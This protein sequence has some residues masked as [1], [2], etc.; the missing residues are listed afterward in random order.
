MRRRYW[1]L[2]ASLLALAIVG[3]ATSHALWAADLALPSPS[4]SAP[5]LAPLP[6][7]DHG[8]AFLRFFTD[9]E[10]YFSWGFSKQYWANSDIH[11]SQP[12]L[13]NGFTV[14]NVQGVD[15]QITA[16]QVF[17]DPFGGEYNIRIGR[18]LSDSRAF[19][20]ELSFDHTKYTTVVGQTANVSGVIGGVPFNGPL[21]LSQQTFSEVLHN[22]A[23]HLMLN[24]VYRLPL[25]G[26][27]DETM[28]LAALGKVG[29]G[30]MLPHTTDTI[31]GNTNFVG[32]KTF[33]NA[34]GLT[35]GWW[36][37]NGW[38]LGAEAA[39]R[40]VIYKPVY[41]EVSDKVAFARLLDL[42]AP[43]GTIQQ[44]LWM[45]EFVVSLGVTYDG[46]STATRR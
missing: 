2:G 6:P 17:G 36:Q 19:G 20:V 21:V 24:A 26:Q 10:W 4:P 35:N 30:V 34:I 16:S 39:L 43:L 7:P 11:V 12:A 13:G 32:T 46:T 18:F 41:L 33:G 3:D 15:D 38:T 31:F 27:I 44:N 23:N 5:A 42:P 40:W 28:S 22:G 8:S 9:A 37:L 29:A 45:N 1:S 25:V 14:Q